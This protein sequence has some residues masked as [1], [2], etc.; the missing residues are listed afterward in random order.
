VDWFRGVDFTKRSE[1]GDFF[2]YEYWNTSSSLPRLN[3]E[4]PSV[5][6]HLFGAIERWINIFNI[7]GLRLDTADVLALDF[8]D[9]LRE[10][11]EKVRPGFW[12]MGEV[13]TGDYRTWTRP[14]RLHS[15][16]NYE[17]HTAMFDGDHESRCGAISSA[18]TRQFGKNG[19]YRNVPLYSF[20]DN[21]DVDRA[22]SRTRDRAELQAMYCV[23]FTMPG[24]PSIYYGSEWGLEAKRTQWDDKMLRPVLDLDKMQSTSDPVLPSAIKQLIEVRKASAALCSG[25]Y[26]ELAVGEHYLVFLR[27]F[28]T[29]SVVV[30]VN[31]GA[32]P[33]SLADAIG[34]IGSGRFCDLLDGG[35]ILD[36]AKPGS[37]VD[38]LPF[39]VRILK[40]VK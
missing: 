35:E 15:V 3:L 33:K 13:V 29:E 17:M 28:E 16:T 32:Q 6:E 27:T 10:H 23:L 30:A 12:L 38:V 31:F 20:A 36:L 19:T 24:V 26:C 37:R 14:G 4:N 21:H 2:A 18:L 22:A 40:V 5:R 7:D 1:R 34:G 11:C 39:W 8:L 9:A 25:S